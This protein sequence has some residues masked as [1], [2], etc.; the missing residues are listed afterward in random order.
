[1]VAAHA[2]PRAV[3]LEHVCTA[4]MAATATDGAAVAVAL[5]ASPRETL[6]TSS[7]IAS[8]A[9]DLSLTLGEGPC[10]EALNGA[11]V[12]VPDLGSSQSL[13]RW[14]TFAPAAMR[15][16]ICAVFALPLQIGAIRLG[17]LDLYRA[18]PGELDRDR[19]LDALV[20]ADTACAVLLGSTERDP[21]GGAPEPVQHPEVHQ[22]TGMVSVQ[23]GVTVA[24]A[25]ARLRAHAYAHERRLRDV[26]RD[27]VARRL[28]FHPDDEDHS[29][30]SGGDGLDGD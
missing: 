30:R 18:E 16:G 14:P 13:T 7:R 11:P 4:A 22:A 12:L 2:G 6:Y 10:V 26:A 15:A 23:L 21:S 17:V 9:E 28:R 3:A 1:M 5:M 20:L 24:L 19:L 8:D 27:V 29:S 25:L